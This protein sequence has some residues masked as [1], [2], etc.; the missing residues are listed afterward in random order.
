MSKLTTLKKAFSIRDNTRRFFTPP[1]HQTAT[2]DGFRAIS[3]L[4]VILFHSFYLPHAAFQEYSQFTDFVQSIPV[5]LSWVWHGDKGV[6]MF[7]ILSGFLIASILIREN[8]RSNS[9]KIGRFYAHR[10]LRILPVYVLILLLVAPSNYNGEYFWA[11]LL[12]INNILPL[13]NILIPWSWSLS[14]E[15]QFYLIFP[16]IL[17]FLL[18]S[19]HPLL[20]LVSLLLLS[21]LSRYA[22]VTANPE[23]YQTPLHLLITQHTDS[24]LI[25]FEKLYINLHT[26]I[27]PLILGVILAWLTHFH[28]SSIRDILSRYPRSMLLLGVTATITV[29]TLVQTQ[30]YN[31]A[32]AHSDSYNL[33]YISLSKPL[34][35]LAITTLLFLTLYGCSI[36]RPLQRF[37]S[38]RIWFPFSQAAYSMYLFH[39]FFIFAIYYLVL[40]GNVKLT[41]LSPFM[42]ITVFIL[43]TLCSLVFSYLVYI[44]IERPFINLYRKNS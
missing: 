37:L 44:L 12:F 19:N 42:P 21:V 33:H 22:V 32:V 24:T 38:L 11:N 25:F 26:R 29:I 8:Q 5:W 13:E 18:K 14:V 10:A 27:T 23:L 34:F 30:T 9:L 43:S 41:S 4:F 6:D 20:W 28:A 3:I 31:P 15:V 16:F 39:I 2:L 36:G 1:A 7:F 40:D 35:S 17:I